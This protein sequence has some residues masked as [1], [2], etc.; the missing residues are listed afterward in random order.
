MLHINQALYYEELAPLDV[1]D[2]LL[3]NVRVAHHRTELVKG[4]LAVLV[5]VREHD[6]LVHDLLQLRVF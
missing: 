2:H 6:C 5:L 4:D 1:H 3:V